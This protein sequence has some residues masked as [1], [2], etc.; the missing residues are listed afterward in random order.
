M[1]KVSER[2]REAMKIRGLK[3]ID[4]VRRTGIDKGTIS[5]YMNDDYGPKGLNLGKI[6]RELNVNEVW[7]AGY[8]AP[9]EREEID[10]SKAL[11]DLES[12]RPLEPWEETLDQDLII[13]ER[14]EDVTR[15]E[16]NL[17]TAYRD[18][19]PAIQA[20]VRKLLDVEDPS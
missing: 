14:T 17:L 12:R 19:D 18:A 10:I 1:K 3:Q 16:M 15:E 11:K 2:M 6:A 5:H 9:M 7:L 20:A 4:I 13:V 8:D